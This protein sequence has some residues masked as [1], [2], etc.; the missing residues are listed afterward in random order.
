MFSAGFLPSAIAPFML[1]LSKAAAHKLLA[2]RFNG[3]VRACWS[4]QI[5]FSEIIHVQ[6]LLIAISAMRMHRLL[7][8]VLGIILI[9]AAFARP[10]DLHSDFLEGLRERQYYD[11]ALLYLD[12][13]EADASVSADARRMIPFERAVTLLAGVGIAPSSEA[14]SRQLDQAVAALQQFAEANPQHP[15][16]AQANSE[17][18][19]ILLG[20]AR[21]AIWQAR[22]APDQNSREEFQKNARSL[23]REAKDICQTALT[24]HEAASKKFPASID[25]RTQ[26]EL[27]QKRRKAE[28]AV[29]QARIDLALCSYG[30]AQ[31]SDSGSPTAVGQFS[32]A[33]GEF[34]AIYNEY[35]NQAGGLVARMWQ[36]KCLEESRDPQKALGVYS[37]LLTQVANKSSLR[38]LRNQIVQFRLAALNHDG[39]KNYDQAIQEANDWLGK[40]RGAESRGPAGLAIRW[41]QAVAQEKLSEQSDQAKE[42]KE[43]LL[44]A[45]LANARFV[46][47]HPGEFRDVAVSKIRDLMVKLHGPKAAQDPEDFDTAYGVARDL[48]TKIQ[49]QNDAIAEAKKANRSSE[50]IKK[51]E[52]SRRLHLQ[53]AARLMG[54]ALSLAD[55]ETPHADL[56]N[57]R[58]VL[59]YVQYLL[60]NSYESAILGEYVAKHYHEGEYAGNA[61]ECAYLA[62]VAY[63]QAYAES[64]EGQ[65]EVDGAAMERVGDL[66]TTYWPK[67]ERADRARLQVGQV[68]R[69]QGQPLE[70][71]KWLDQI[72]KESPRYAEA[73]GSLG[74][75]FWM[76]YLK[77]VM[78]PEGE[79]PPSDELRKWQD[80]ALQHLQNSVTATEQ[81]IGG[82]KTPPE[83]VS[84]KVSLV[85]ILL[86]KGQ[87]DRAATVLTGSPHSV[88]E[89]IAVPDGTKRPPG[90]NI[91]ST[92]FAS[93]VYQLQL[94]AYVGMQKLSEARKAM[95]SLEKVASATGG[96]EAVTAIYVEL[97]KQLEQ[98]LKRLKG[99]G[100]QQRLAEVRTSFENFLRDLFERPGQ[101]LASLVW[102]AETYYGLAEGTEDDEAEAAMY[103]DNAAAS[104]QEILKRA[105]EDPSFIDPATLFAV[106]LRQVNCKRRQG[107]FE[108]AVDI[109]AELLQAKPNSLEGQVEA[110]YA[111]QEWGT[112]GDKKVSTQKLRLAMLGGPIGKAKIACWGWGQIGLNLQRLL[113][114]G[115]SGDRDKYQGKLYEARYNA[116]YCRHQYALAQGQGPQIKE[117]LERAKNEILAFASITDNVD[118]DWWNRFDKLYRTIQKDLGEQPVALEKPTVPVSAPAAVATRTTETPKRDAAAP[119]KKAA[120]ARKKEASGSGLGTM[121]LCVLL[122]G[123]GGAIIF[124]L[125]KSQTRRPRRV[126]YGAPEV[127]VLPPGRPAQATGAPKAARSAKPAATRRKPAGAEGPQPQRKPKRPKDGPSQP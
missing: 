36:G 96:G 118:P 38:S 66:I 39:L 5:G 83:L 80:A 2:D 1:E 35:R 4:R 97:G 116:A 127:P 90:P 61:L 18:G 89:A 33:A 126:Q 95:D 71:A 106:K 124:F 69:D 3:I 24:Q 55:A 42:D 64:P 104:Y 19:R 56:I 92:E 58:Y 113:A 20:K 70:A 49:T 40:N 88:I 59:S 72:P 74:Q 81:K 112:R 15:K 34:E 94:R 47:E 43:R 100:D 63:G 23:V 119:R 82:G 60:G 114:A 29:I 105:K 75:T 73:Q 65:K 122:F 102:I 46:S 125:V 14:Q 91:Q 68:Y 109:A 22:S 123:A 77:S 67:S 11:Y 52:E 6:A 87:Y 103:F 86:S 17:R 115:K 110:A 27:F 30:E 84:A 101:T 8:T 93:L 44:R 13:L 37:E 26:K 78:L 10:A 7:A 121:I 54:L 107:D 41:Q 12:Q 51:L 117:Q 120:P 98:E 31:T 16:A 62:L 50:E 25:E 28:V 57:A 45:A 21:L 32:R 79:R 99:L 108:G 53:E 85:Q 111:L 48:V 9:P 76:A